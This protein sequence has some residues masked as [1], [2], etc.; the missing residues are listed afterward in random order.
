MEVVILNNIVL[1]FRD[2]T[3]VLLYSLRL[4]GSLYSRKLVVHFVLLLI[5]LLNTVGI[6]MI[7]IKT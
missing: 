5:F 6:Y 4:G 2:S 3:I 1:I 7:F